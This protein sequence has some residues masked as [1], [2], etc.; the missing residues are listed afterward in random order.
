ME[1]RLTADLD[2]KPG[3]LVWDAG[4]FEG[5]WSRDIFER[6]GIKPLVFEPVPGYAADLRAKGFHVEQ[7]G[8]SDYDHEATITVAGDRSSTFEMGYQGTDKVKIK[9]RDISAVIGN[10]KI[11]VLKLNCEGCEYALLDR[12]IA[13]GKIS[14]V[15]TLLIQFHCFV[16]QYGEKYLAL[17]RAML[18]THSLAWRESFVWERWNR[19]AG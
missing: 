9:L 6:Y 10:A 17:K 5:A 3:D 18:H 16:E 15:G 8:L 2:I 14:Q 13:T 11:A 7:V 4:G 19:N 1:S 12:L